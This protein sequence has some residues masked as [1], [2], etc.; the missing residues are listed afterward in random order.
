MPGDPSHPWPTRDHVKI[1]SEEPSLPT[2]SRVASPATPVILY[3]VTIVF[4]SCH[5]T[6]NILSIVCLL[7]LDRYKVRKSRTHICPIQ[8]FRL[9]LAEANAETRMWDP[10]ADL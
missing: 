2:L 7:P 1:S 9:V 4:S 5:F 8:H 6:E 10:V 3:H